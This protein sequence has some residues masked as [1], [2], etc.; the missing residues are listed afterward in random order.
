M[1]TTPSQGA[2]PLWRTIVVRPA[3]ITICPIPIGVE[4]PRSYRLASNARLVVTRG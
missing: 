3:Q 1:D 4:V 2:P